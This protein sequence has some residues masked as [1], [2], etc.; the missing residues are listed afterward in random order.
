MLILQSLRSPFSGRNDHEDEFGFKDTTTME[1]RLVHCPPTSLVPRI[2]CILADKL[3][4]TNPFLT[5]SL[6]SEIGKFLSKRFLLNSLPYGNFHETPRHVE[7]RDH[8]QG[9]Y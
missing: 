8:I 6:D 1:E 4:H 5:R 3:L 9:S 2:H 7:M